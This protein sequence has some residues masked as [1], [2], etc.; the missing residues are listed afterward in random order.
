MSVIVLAYSGGRRSRRALRELLASGQDV[1]TLTLDVG[2]GGDLSDIRGE[3]LA[4]G[5]IRAHVLD[6]REVFSAEILLPALRA[7]ARLDGHLPTPQA[8]FA[9]LLASQLAILARMEATSLVAHGAGHMLKQRLDA[10]T[11]SN[12]PK[13]RVVPTPSASDLPD[14]QD[15]EGVPAADCN[16]WGRTLHANFDGDTWNEA[17]ES[18]F[19]LTNAPVAASDLPALVEVECEA[20]VPTAVNGIP[21]SFLD[22]FTSLET[23]AGDHG[24]GRLDIID[25]APNGAA[26]RV[27]VEAP[28]AVVL[29]TALRALEA[30]VYDPAFGELARDFGD[31]YGEMLAEGTWSTDA[32]ESLQAF[33]ARSH[34]RLSGTVRLRLFKG[35]CRVVGRRSPFSRCVKIG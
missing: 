1:A 13:L 31:A 24:V 30:L 5:A 19:T 29:D 16:V 18:L 3:A 6:A 7:G 2:Q 15:D 14:L 27:V 9:P 21:M 10:G 11:Q 22:L 20:G 4:N 17:D 8:L 32:R 12:V 28:A 26:H 33:A 34:H 35:E 23:I 25:R